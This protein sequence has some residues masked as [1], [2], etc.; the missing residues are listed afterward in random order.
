MN[1]PLFPRKRHCHY[2]AQEPYLRES[3]RSLFF[4]IAGVQAI[5]KHIDEYFHDEWG[6][7]VV[8][9][10]FHDTNFENLEVTNLFICWSKSDEIEA[11]CFVDEDDYLG[12]P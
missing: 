9:E 10:F 4:N 3:S 11:Y 1:L 2:P 12:I 6:N 7:I 5:I 8:I